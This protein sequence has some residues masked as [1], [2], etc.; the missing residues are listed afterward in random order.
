M[1]TDKRLNKRELKGNFV[2]LRSD[3]L[4]LIL[5]Q[6]QVAS[7]RRLDSGIK[8]VSDKGKSGIYIAKS[9]EKGKKSY[10]A[11]LSEQMTLF[12]KLPKSRFLLTT[13]HKSKIQWCWDDVFVLI[14]TT[15]SCQ[16]IP[17]VLRKP[18]TPLQA[19]A[20]WSDGEE[21]FNG[22]LCSSDRVVRYVMNQ[23][24]QKQKM[25]GGKKI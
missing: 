7:T 15:V 9:A 11:A 12:P 8:M 1:S 22:F 5:P 25:K 21:L 16:E 20:T 4:W 24:K 23:V 18:S 6:E 2:A 17:K 19:L 3:D 10:Y 13:F 14:D